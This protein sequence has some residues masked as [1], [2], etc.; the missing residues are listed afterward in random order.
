M[1][2]GCPFRIDECFRPRPRDVG[3]TTRILP[4]EGGLLF[5]AIIHLQLDESHENNNINEVQKSTPHPSPDNNNNDDKP[6]TRH[7]PI[8]DRVPAVPSC[9]LSF[10]AKIQ[11]GRFQPTTNPAVDS[12]N[13]NDAQRTC[14][15]NRVTAQGT[16]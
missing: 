16:R 14:S 7:Q 2:D 6:G 1:K 8:R 9:A 15:L 5:S 3:T 11:K 12:L 4:S 13:R 10:H